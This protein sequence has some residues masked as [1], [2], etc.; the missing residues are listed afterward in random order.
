M[1][2][3][4]N[5]IISGT[6]DSLLEPVNPFMATV[7]GAMFYRCENNRDWDMNYVNQTCES[8]TECSVDDVLS[9]KFSFGKM[10]HPSDQDM[11]WETVQLALDGKSPYQLLYRIGTE[12]EDEKFLFE[13]GHGIFSKVGKLTE[14]T[15]FILDISNHIHGN[16][17]DSLLECCAKELKKLVDGND[18]IGVNSTQLSNREIEII[19][20]ICQGKTM[21][22][23]GLDLNISPRTVEMHLKNSKSKL[24]CRTQLELRKLFFTIE[25][26]RRLH[27]ALIHRQF[28]DHLG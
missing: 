2:D 27:C 25:S 14:L 1:L 23:V 21:K 19:A 22:E 9:R 24:K 17:V 12:N 10:I 16:D 4:K 18:K 11:V 26:G 20:N 13:Q 3:C 7:G 5:K 6:T 8:I 15:G 28:S